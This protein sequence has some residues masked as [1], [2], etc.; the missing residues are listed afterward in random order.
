LLTVEAS[1]SDQRFS[2]KQL[3]GGLQVILIL[4]LIGSCSGASDN[5]VTDNDVDDEVSA[6]QRSTGGLRHEVRELR[7]E[8]R[9]LRIQAAQ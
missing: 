8:V 4:I 3:S 1:P 2:F 9:R 6:L 7:R 5:A